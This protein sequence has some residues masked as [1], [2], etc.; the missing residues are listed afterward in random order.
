MAP[1]KN[2]RVHAVIRYS[3]RTTAWVHSYS[4]A[5]FKALSHMLSI[6]YGR[7][8]PQTIAEVWLTIGSML[9]G[10]TFY[11]LFIGQ[12]SSI[13]LRLDSAGKAYAEKVRNALT[14]IVPPL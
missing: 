14:A 3:N 12:I 6:G 11:A 9:V 10:A 4:W 7:D 8:S 5:L 1:S 13:M 2:A